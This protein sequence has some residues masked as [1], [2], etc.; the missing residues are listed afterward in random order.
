MK[1]LVML[2]V[3]VVTAAC[4]AMLSWQ[5]VQAQ[6][7]G[8]SAAD[9]QRSVEQNRPD[10]NRTAPK[11]AAK[12][13]AAPVTYDQGFA[14]LKEVKV[15]SAL[16]QQELADYWRDAINKPVSAQKLTDFKAKA[17]E[18]FQS[19][20]YLA[21]ISTSAQATP[22]GSVLTVLVSMPVVGRVTVLPVD[23]ETVNRELVNEVA[24]RFKEI[25][26]TGTPVDVQGFEAQLNA[27]AYDLPVDLEISLRQV[28]SKVVDVT[29]HLRRA[30][31]Q[32]G[33][34]LGG[35]VQGN[36]YGLQQFGRTQVLG[37]VRVQGF[38]P[39]SELALTTQISQGV[40]YYRAEY[41]APVIGTGM[42]WRTYGSQVHSYAKGVQGL[43]EE[44]GLGLNKLL[45]TN[46]S[47]RWISGIE[48][49]K[50]QAQNWT[51]GVA[52]ANR[53][54]H[55]LRVKLRGESSKHWVDNFYNEFTLISGNINLDRNNPD[56]V[57]DSN[58]RRVAGNYQ[59]LEANGGLSQ[60]LDK[61]RYVT[62]SMRWR[63][64]TATK[65]LDTY[66]KISMGGVNGIRSLTSLDGAGDQGAQLSFDII[67]Q[68]IPTAWGGLFYDIG[69]VVSN[70]FEANNPG[71]VTLEGAGWQVGGKEGVVT[72]SL[73]V[74]K[75]FGKTT[76]SWTP[77]NTQNGDWRGNFAVTH[78][79]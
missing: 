42:H 15:Q 56:M 24:R 54:D 6:S 73:S 67:H 64:Q 51:S 36:N 47:G 46:R 2:N 32:V 18:L 48:L 76:N 43:S 3:R 28:D 23:A 60:A 17:W 26:P 49:S 63:A 50:R 27:A 9:V 29:I 19:K 79:F 62:G 55:Q 52:T 68:A 53:I 72:W 75:F 22:E 59:K 74:G 69:V 16:F 57:D 12:L 65:N 58:N 21:Y 77:T 37:N 70:K 38:T 1:V 44:V 4:L 61:D 35:F 33:K 25:Y 8:P 13:P 41:E 7:S 11:P 31:A 71:Y 14:R 20:G 30:E 10:L 39:S 66:N 78:A 5:S 45:Q 40:G 34:V